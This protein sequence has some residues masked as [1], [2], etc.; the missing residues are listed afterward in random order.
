ML[1][2]VFDFIEVRLNSPCTSTGGFALCLR[3]QACRLTA[4]FVPEKC[5]TPTHACC[6]LPEVSAA[7]AA[8]ARGGRVLLHCSQGV[9]RSASLAIAY[10][11][12]KQNSTFD[13]TLAAVKAIRGVANPNIGF[14]C[15]VWAPRQARK[16]Q[17]LTLIVRGTTLSSSASSG[18]IR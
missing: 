8:K 17:K 5:G 11:M 2:D 13:S 1:Y 10:L 3:V 18:A 15:Q 7:Q 6:M 12:W 14:T 16:L 4:C 9:S